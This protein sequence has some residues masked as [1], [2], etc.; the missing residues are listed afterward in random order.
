MVPMQISEA[1]KQYHRAEDELKSLG[2][3]AKARINEVDKAI[4]AD[5]S[6][7]KSKASSWWGGSKS[8]S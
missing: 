5:V 1:N 3:D 4:E 8:S 2:H 6:K 7:A